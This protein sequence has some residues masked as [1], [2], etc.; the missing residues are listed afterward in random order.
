[1]EIKRSGS[2]PSGILLRLATADRKERHEEVRVTTGEQSI[3]L[4]NGN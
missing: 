4:V 2:Q 3:R 1:M